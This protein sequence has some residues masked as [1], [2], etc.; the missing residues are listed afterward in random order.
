MLS[1]NASFAQQDS[2][3]AAYDAIQKGNTDRALKAIHAALQNP[4]TTGDFMAWYLKAYILKDVSKKQSGEAAAKSRIESLEALK[5]SLDLDKKRENF[6]QDSALLKYLGSK[7]YNDA[8]SNLNTQGFEKAILYFDYYE[9]CFRLMSPNVDLQLR[10]MDF[11]LALASVYTSIYEGNRKEKEAF[12]EKTVALYKDVLR[13]DPDNISANYSLGVLY[14]NKAVAIINEMDFETDLMA[15]SETQDKTLEIF[16][17]SLPFMEKAYQLNPKRKETLIG[18][19]GIYYSLNETEK[20][21]K[22]KQELSTLDK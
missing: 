13:V 17:Q 4:A 21:N 1:G 9:Q 12:F 20:L 18:L 22:I 2:V 11:K 6:A 7:F 15:L 19:E 3:A 10:E 14:Y 5:V 8:S 16:K